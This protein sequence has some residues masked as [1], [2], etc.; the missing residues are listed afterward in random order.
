MQLAA[1]NAYCPYEIGDVL[2]NKNG[3][4]MGTITDIMTIHYIKTG[5][6]EFAIQINE[7]PTWYKVK[8]YAK[9]KSL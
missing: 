3:M 1:F 6:V 5:K 9:S 2:K 4:P 7:L 8:S